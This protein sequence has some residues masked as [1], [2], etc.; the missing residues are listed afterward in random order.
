MP[1]YIGTRRTLFGKS[2]FLPFL[3]DFNRAN[4]ALGDPWTGATFTVASNKAINT[5]TEGS[6]L[7]TNGDFANWTADDPD[8]WTITETTQDITEVAT[9]EAHA[10]APT[11]GGGFCNIYRSGGG[12]GADP[13]ML[14]S[15]VSA[16]TW[17]SIRVTIDTATSG[18]L[19]INDGEA[20]GLSYNFAAT[21]TKRIA[22]L[23]LGAFLVIN[24]SADPTDMTFDDVTCKALTLSEI[25]AS[26]KPS[27]ADVVADVDVTLALDD[28]EDRTSA[29]LVLRLDS[30][31]SPANFII[32][33]H[34]GVQAILAKCVA[35]TYTSLINTI[36]A[37]SAGA[38]LRVILDGSSVDLF[39]NEV[40][41]GS[42]QSVSDAGILNNTLHGLLS[43]YS[44]DTLDNFSMREL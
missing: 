37:Y 6:D 30:A 41:V 27:Q 5:P 21:G 42:T 2:S 32:A 3:D 29:G 4:G 43:T 36:T 40:K 33:Y 39:Y 11:I 22:G 12:S 14:Q 35:G 24:T 20:G 10:D 16:G 17:Y 9:G 15:F 26:L 18:G 23:A 34:D 28:A 25:F 8:D 19:R 38:T 44:G 7:V 31:A 1:L 13:R